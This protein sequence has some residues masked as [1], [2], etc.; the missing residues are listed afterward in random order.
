MAEQP[1]PEPHL[2][3]PERCA[4]LRIVLVTV[5]RVSRSCEHFPDGYLGEDLLLELGGDGLGIR[6]HRR[7]EDDDL[8]ELRRVQGL[9]GGSRA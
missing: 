1:A 2:A 5:P 3:H 8:V 7:R 6:L 4:A 9:G